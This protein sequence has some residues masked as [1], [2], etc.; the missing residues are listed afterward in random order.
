MILFSIKGGSTNKKRQCPFLYENGYK[1]H[2]LVIEKVRSVYLPKVPILCGLDQSANMDA[3][4]GDG[5][6]HF[7]FCFKEIMAHMIL[8]FRKKD[9]HKQN[10]ETSIFGQKW[11]PWIC[12]GNKKLLYSWV[13]SRLVQI[14]R[15]TLSPGTYLKSV[16]QVRRVEDKSRFY[17]P[18]KKKLKI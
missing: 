15:H 17:P 6:S 1:W 14:F 10:M 18:P 11:L 2:V 13:V 9:R 8:T 16:G 5:E 7:L 12:L 4:L 3:T